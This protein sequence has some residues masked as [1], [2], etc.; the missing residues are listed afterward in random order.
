M[1][2]RMCNADYKGI[3]TEHISEELRMACRYINELE[4]VGTVQIFWDFG[5]LFFSCLENYETYGNSTDTPQLTHFSKGKNTIKNLNHRI[6]ACGNESAV[7][8]G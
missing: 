8:R 3:A 6:F 4:N 7:K 2:A 1:V 5:L